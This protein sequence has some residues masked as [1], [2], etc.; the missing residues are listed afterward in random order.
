MEDILARI[1]LFAANTH[2]WPFEK[3]GPLHLP[4]SLMTRKHQQTAPTSSVPVK[5]EGVL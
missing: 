5:P 3:A 1:T 2:S 4:A